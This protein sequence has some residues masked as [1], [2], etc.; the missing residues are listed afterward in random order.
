[1]VTND[2]GAVL[3]MF[4]QGEMYKNMREAGRFGDELTS[5]IDEGLIKA[6]SAIEGV[7]YALGELSG[8]QENMPTVIAQNIPESIWRSIDQMDGY[9]SDIILPRLLD[10]ERLV[11]TAMNIISTYNS[12]FSDL[13]TKL[14]YPGTNLLTIDDLP[15]YAKQ[16]EQWAIDEVS[17]RMF[18]DAADSDRA[19]MQA[20]LDAFEIIDKAMTAPL[21]EPEFMTIESPQRA[22]LHGIVVEPQETWFVGG[23]KS[24]Y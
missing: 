17:G 3:E 13:A 19:G 4:F 2:P 6:R 10:A 23:Y 9:I 1:M 7:Q 5:K 8:I 18:N 20:D 14:A 16:S 24:P 21:P 12:K 22:A 15:D 11:E